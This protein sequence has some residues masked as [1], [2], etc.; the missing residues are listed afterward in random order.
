MI[1]N[2]GGVVELLNIDVK[3]AGEKSKENAEVEIKLENQLKQVL[4]SV[5]VRNDH[6]RLDYG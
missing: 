4:F 5:F 1:E 2:G 3:L 6:S